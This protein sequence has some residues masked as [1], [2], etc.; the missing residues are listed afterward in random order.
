VPSE[1][2]AKQ[3]KKAAL[4]PFPFSSTSSRLIDLVTREK[5]NSLEKRKKN[6]KTK[7]TEEKCQGDQ[8]KMN[9]IRKERRCCTLA[10]LAGFSEFPL[11]DSR[12]DG[13][14]WGKR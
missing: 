8:T 10:L 5:R 12:D 13:I 7:G 1:T 2:Q 4:M 6:Q 3:T 9:E 11:R 14:E